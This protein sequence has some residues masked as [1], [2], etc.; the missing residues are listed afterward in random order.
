MRE[1]TFN[2][3]SFIPP[4]LWLITITALTLSG[5]A[6]SQLRVTEESTE[7]IT[8]KSETAADPE[9][10][11]LIEPY[12]KAL[13]AEMTE[14]IGHAPTEISNRS[15]EVESALGNFVADLMLSESIRH[16]GEAI[17][18]SLVNTRGG[19]RVPI[20]KGDIQVGNIFELMPF[21]NDVW[22]LSLT[23]EETKA[24]FDHCAASGMMA[25]SGARYRIQEGKAV[26]IVIRG[27]P[28]DLN[29]TYL[30]AL[31]D[32]LATG[33]AGFGFLDD[34]RVVS[35]L[36]VKVRDMIIT[37]I[38]KLGAQGIPVESKLDGRVTTLP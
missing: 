35:N 3:R 16:F 12:K 14:V 36:L 37:H 27:N 29:Q 38:R 30:V 20:P 25:L 23:G 31:P 10:A 15:G 21:D 5:C 8:V 24:V 33:G 6:T 28:L 32:Y 17:H 22:I 1:R 18:F 2:T 11:Q 26:D 19:L 7:Y 34:A 4:C 13:D 9:V